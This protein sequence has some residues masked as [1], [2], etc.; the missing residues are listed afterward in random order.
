VLEDTCMSLRIDSFFPFILLAKHTCVNYCCTPHCGEG[1]GK[2]FGL[3][4]API[5]HSVYFFY[6]RSFTMT[7]YVLYL[8]SLFPIIYELR[9][10]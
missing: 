8:L 7:T 1:G 9:Y 3:L 2:N 6:F 5:L 4:F 10:S